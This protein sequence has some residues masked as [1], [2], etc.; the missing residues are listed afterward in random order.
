MTSAAILWAGEGLSTRTAGR[1]PS[2]T[3]S[4]G[5]AADNFRSDDDWLA[6]WGA[7]LDAPAH[8]ARGAVVQVEFVDRTVLFASDERP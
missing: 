4:G 5:R 2:V 3:L 8:I 6:S 1:P 7:C